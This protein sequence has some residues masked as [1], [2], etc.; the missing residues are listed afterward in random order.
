MTT[1]KLTS[2]QARQAE[3]L[4]KFNFVVMYQSGQKNDKANALTRR[5][6]KQSINNKNERQKHV[7]QVL[8]LLARIE[9]QSIEAVYNKL[10]IEPKKPRVAEP[11]AEPQTAEKNIKAED[12]KEF[13]NHE[14]TDCHEKVA[15]QKS[16]EAKH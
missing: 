6:N 3:F 14:K 7:I 9:K 1:K 8:L 5:L 13:T 2:K 10:K 11:S 4:S 16:V 15:C 12:T